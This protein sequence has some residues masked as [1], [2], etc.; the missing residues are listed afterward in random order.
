MNT[1]L[2]ATDGSASADR[3]VAFAAQLANTTHAK[4]AIFAVSE[5]RASSELKAFGEAEHVTTGDMLESELNGILA[6]ARAR[7]NS[8]R[9]HDIETQSEMGDPAALIL[10]KAGALHADAIVAG[11]R[12]RGQ[13]SGLLLGS[14]SQKLVTLAPCPVVIVP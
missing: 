10:K 7:A 14:V 12:G 3:A 11:K 13:L 9:V 1:V 2:V 4:L 5:G 8:L 6:G